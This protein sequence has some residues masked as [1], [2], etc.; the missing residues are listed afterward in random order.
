MTSSLQTTPQ[1]P[2]SKKTQVLAH[3]HGNIGPQGLLVLIVM[4]YLCGQVL[5]R[6]NPL[7]ATN[8]LLATLAQVLLICPDRCPEASLVTGDGR[9]L[10]KN[11]TVPQV[12][13]TRGFRTSLFVLGA[14]FFPTFFGTS[15]H[16]VKLELSGP[17]QTNRSGLHAREA[18]RLEATKISA[19]CDGPKL[20][21]W[22]R[23]R[24]FQTESPIILRNKQLAVLH[25]TSLP[26]IA[27][28]CLQGINHCTPAL[29]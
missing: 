17:C 25:V 7:I 27:A 12:F 13:M 4:P 26:N 3:I 2:A 18:V 1:A 22:Y 20:H 11:L 6:N 16:A 24:V 8:G 5:R 23:L 15:Q 21:H 14:T 29:N 28:P 9:K 19:R 10:A